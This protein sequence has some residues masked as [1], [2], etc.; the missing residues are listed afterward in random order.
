MLGKCWELGEVKRIIP[1]QSREY[2][3]PGTAIYCLKN[4]VY[5]SIG[6]FLRNA[7]TNKWGFCQE[8]IGENVGKMLGAGARA[9]S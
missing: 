3:Q 9:Y 1:V 2:N 7:F 6:V 8:K 5:V 4:C